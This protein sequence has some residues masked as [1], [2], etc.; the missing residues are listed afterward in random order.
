MGAQ[1]RRIEWSSNK[2]RLMVSSWVHNRTELRYN[3]LA[4]LWGGV[5]A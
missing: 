5:L 4:V 1:T 2:R 3:C